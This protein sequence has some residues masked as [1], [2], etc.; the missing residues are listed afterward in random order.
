[1]AKAVQVIDY[2][3]IGTKGFPIHYEA[4]GLEPPRKWVPVDED[5]NPLS[6]HAGRSPQE[7]ADYK[8]I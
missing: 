6:D 8:P 7:L 1:M 5:G 4:L 2:A 3:R